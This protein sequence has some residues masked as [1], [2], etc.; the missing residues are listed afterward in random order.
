MIQPNLLPS[1]LQLL[2]PAVHRLHPV[3]RAKTR[4]RFRVKARA[5]VRVKAKVLPILGLRRN[6]WT[7]T[8]G[9]SNMFY[10]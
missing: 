6:L 4:V 2:H 3:L 9:K 7:S 1:N 5:K 8:L 10:R